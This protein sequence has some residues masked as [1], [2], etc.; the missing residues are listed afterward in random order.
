MLA[1]QHTVAL[2][3]AGISTPSGIPDFRSPGDGLWQQADPEVVASLA[4]FRRN[5]RAFGAWLRPLVQRIV[6]AESN[7]AHCA[8]AAL[9]KAGLVRTI[10]TQ[11][12][13]GLHQRAGSQR[14]L[15]LHGHLREAS[16]LRC[17]YQTSADGLIETFLSSGEPPGCPRCGGA[18]KPAVVLFGEMLPTDVLH[19]AQEEATTCDLMLVAGSSLSVAPASLLPQWAVDH[20]SRLIIINQAPTSL[21][22]LAEVVL[23]DDLAE[24][25]PAVAAACG[26][27]ASHFR[28]RSPSTPDGSAGDD[29]RFAGAANVESAEET[30]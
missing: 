6:S 29:E 16:C 19:E 18:L 8:L 23:W 30:P 21:D 17:G 27:G 22:P 14:V 13:D 9:E 5:P 3:G 20:G 28:S 2:T 15:E 4:G 26:V 11:N 7:A 24:V 25:L 10:I 12:I 1:A